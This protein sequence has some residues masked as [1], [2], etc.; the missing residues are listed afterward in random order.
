V[1]A[2]GWRKLGSG[3]SRGTGAQCSRCRGTTG[4]QAC[5]SQLLDLDT[6]RWSMGLWPCEA[7]SDWWG[8]ALGVA[9][10]AS[11]D[12]REGHL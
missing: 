5:M 7:L 4:L 12:R 2:E 6:W 11:V 3:L 8:S 9:G 1:E 10:G